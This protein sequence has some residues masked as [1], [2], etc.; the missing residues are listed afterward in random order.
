M[1]KDGNCTIC[2]KKCP[3]KEHKNRDYILED[4]V[5][6]KIITLEELKKRYNYSKGELSAKRKIFLGARDVFIN[7][8]KF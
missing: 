7:S 3:W 8:Y 5:E 6:E 2:P 1:D 4:Y